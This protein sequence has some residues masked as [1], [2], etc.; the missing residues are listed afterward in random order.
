VEKFSMQ[1]LNH[2]LAELEEVDLK[3]K[4]TPLSTQTLLESFIFDYCSLRKKERI[5]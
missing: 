1:D 2:I 5:T 4:T 3:I